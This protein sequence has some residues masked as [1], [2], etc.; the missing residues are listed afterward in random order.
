MWVADDGWNT[1]GFYRITIRFSTET[2]IRCGHF[3]N[4]CELI[5]Q[6][7]LGQVFTFWVW[8]RAI[9]IPL[10]MR[11]SLSLH[12]NYEASLSLS[13]P[14]LQLLTL[15]LDIKKGS[16]VG[17]GNISLL[18]R[19]TSASTGVHYVAAGCPSQCHRGTSAY[20]QLRVNSFS[21]ASWD[22]LST[23]LYSPSKD[24]KHWFSHRQLS[25]SSSSAI[26]LKKTAQMSLSMVQAMINL[27]LICQV[28][29]LSTIESTF[30]S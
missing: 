26:F 19:Q 21:R 29:Q 9:K 12:D 7:L 20:V 8:W 24:L 16:P 5:G 22:P 30:V 2:L 14:I 13:R 11:S 25:G 4:H 3:V 1:R 15:V 6:G 10:R 28:E 23:S 18:R 27:Y 17:W